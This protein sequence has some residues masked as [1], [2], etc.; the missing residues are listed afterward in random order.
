MT[1]YPLEEALCPND[2]IGGGSCIPPI[3]AFVPSLAGIYP[4]GSK[5]TL[6]S[7]LLSPAVA[8]RFL[9][10]ARLAQG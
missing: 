5:R 6:A 1:Y 4:L 2:L 7:R 3:L 8:S 10:G 9:T